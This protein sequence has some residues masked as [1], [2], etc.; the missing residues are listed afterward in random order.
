[1]ASLL[2]IFSWF[3]VHYTSMNNTNSLISGD[4]KGYASLICWLCEMFSLI[5]WLLETFSWF[6]VHCTSMNNTNGLISGDNKGYAS[7][8][9]WLC[10]MFSLIQWLL[11]TFSWFAVHCT[12]MNNTN[13]L[14]SGDNKGY[15]SQLFER[16]ML[17]HGELSTPVSSIA[18]SCVYVSR[19]DSYVDTFVPMEEE[20]RKGRTNWNHTKLIFLNSSMEIISS[21]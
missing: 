2:E 9:C 5:Q 3:P 18:P 19:A 16:Y 10:E 17:A 15:A 1:M 14:I 21:P 20:K 8:T 7:L 11:E 13:G 4:N 12:S 6:A